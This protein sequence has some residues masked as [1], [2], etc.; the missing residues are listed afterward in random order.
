M[1]SETRCRTKRI[2]FTEFIYLGC[3]DVLGLVRSWQL[4]GVDRC[5]HNFWN[6]IKPKSSTQS[7]YGLGL[8]HSDESKLKSLEWC[9]DSRVSVKKNTFKQVD[10]SKFSMSN[11]RFV[12]LEKWHQPDSHL[13]FRSFRFKSGKMSIILANIPSSGILVRFTTQSQSIC[14]L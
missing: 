7:I 5:Q 14:W 2:W 11:A 1:R 6:E 12:S 8:R 3:T 13:L 10:P 9:A 4:F